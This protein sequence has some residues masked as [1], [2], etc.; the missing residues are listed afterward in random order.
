MQGF[1]LE[2]IKAE[3]RQMFQDNASLLFKKV[4]EGGLG[5]AKM[6]QLFDVNDKKEFLEKVDDLR[7]SEIYG[8][9]E[10]L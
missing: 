2:L 8:F 1:D 7:D 6:L 10:L 3:F 9:I 4:E 5:Q